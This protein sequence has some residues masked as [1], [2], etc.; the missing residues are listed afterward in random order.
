M[1]RRP[2]RYKRTDTLF[3]DT[4]L[5]RSIAENGQHIR[6]DVDLPE[7]DDMPSKRAAVPARGLKLSVKEFPAVQ[8][9]KRYM[10][11][12][13]GVGFRLIG[14]T[15]AALP[16]ARRVTLSGYSQRN[17]PATGQARDDYLYSVSVDRDDWARI[18]FELLPILDEIE[19]RRVGKECVSTCR[20]RWS[21]YL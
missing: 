18:D 12:V 8:V 17:D 10:A 4:T 21:P 20:S 1:L 2:P 3:P 19:E 16:S 9:R 5:F 13:H 11:H 15:F 14:E 7:I 6:L